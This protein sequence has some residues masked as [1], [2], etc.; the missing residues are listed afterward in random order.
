MPLVIAFPANSTTGSEGDAANSP[1][2]SSS[3]NHHSLSP[4]SNPPLPPLRLE[5]AL[6]EMLKGNVAWDFWNLDLSCINSP[7]TLVF[8]HKIFLP[9]FCRDIHKFE[10][11]ITEAA[12]FPLTILW[13]V[14][15]FQGIVHINWALSKY[16]TQESEHIPGYGMQKVISLRCCNKTVTKQIFTMFNN[17]F[18]R[19]VCRKW[20]L[21]TYHKW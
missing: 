4:S 20:P 1:M 17:L 19:M 21:S 6:K 9:R 8:P 3:F 10:Y 14:L 2:S 18:L 7:E 11:Q 12:H 13:K 16:H 15:T 5:N